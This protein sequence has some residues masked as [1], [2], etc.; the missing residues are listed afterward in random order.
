MPFFEFQRTGEAVHCQGCG[1]VIVVGGFCYGPILNDDGSPATDLA[2]TAFVAPCEC[3]A[4]T[5]VARS[6]SPFDRITP[7]AVVPSDAGLI[8]L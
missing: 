4:R 2:G 7:V 1:K 5:P 3:G 6:T 8:A